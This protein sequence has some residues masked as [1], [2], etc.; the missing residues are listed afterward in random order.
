MVEYDTNFRL[1]MT[2]NMRNPHYLPEVV[3]LVTIVNFSLTVEGLTD[4]LLGL[5]VACDR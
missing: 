3:N 4:Q 2:S 5:I 1:Y